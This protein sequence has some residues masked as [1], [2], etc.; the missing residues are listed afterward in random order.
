[1]GDFANDVRYGFRLMRRSPAFAAIAVATLA[2]GIGANT[3]IFSVVNTVLLRPLSYPQPD[4]IV[5]LERSYP[6]G[7]YGSAVS[8][9]KFNFWKR[10]TAFS[11]VAAYD[12]NSAEFNLGSSDHPEQVKTVHVSAG[13][14]QVFGTTPV[15][16]RTFTAEEDTPGGPRVAVI[17]QS[18]WNRR[19][20][21]SPTVIGQTA[22]L[23]GD[24]Y[25]IV[26]IL[27]GSFRP[28]PPADVWIPL[29][30][31]PNSTNQGHYLRVAARLKP[32]V[33]VARAQAE[34]VAMGQAFRQAYPGDMDK[35][36]SV[37]V[38]PLREAETRNVRL[39]LMILMGA[40]LFVLL[41]A[42]ANMANLLLSRA[43][44]RRKEIAIRSA[45]G[46]NAWRVVRQLLTESVLLAGIGGIA[47]SLLGLVGVR[48]LL[49]ASP[50][51]IPRIQDLSQASLWSV[52]DW[53]V[54]LFVGGISVLTGVIFG[55][56]PALHVLR[57]DLSLTLKESSSRGSSAG[58]QSRSRSVLMVVQL[59]LALVLLTGAG[60]LIRTYLHLQ[61]VQP[62]IN[63]RDVLT[64][65]TS[66]AGSKYKTTASVAQ[67]T[68]EV[69]QRVEALPGVRS[70]A[71][72][73]VLPMNNEVDLPF[74]IP[75]HPPAHGDRWN[76]DEQWRMVTPRYFETF[77][78][79]LLRGRLFDDRD[80]GRSSL[81]VVINQAMAQ[82]YWPHQDALGQQ[83]VIGKGLGPQFEEPA[84]QIIGIVGNVRETGLADKQW[85]GVMY[86]PVAQ[87]TD[88]LMAFGLNVIPMSWAVKT[89]GAP[90]TLIPAVQ[91]QIT[92]VDASIAATDFQTMDQVIAATIARQAMTTQLLSLFAAIA[93]LLA[94][95]G[96]YG[97]MSYG[98]E[99][100][101][102]EM[103][104]R[105]A[106]GAGRGNIMRLVLWQAAKLAI[107]GVV[108]GLLAALALSRVL[109]AILFGVKA[110]DPVAFTSVA[111]LLS[112]VVLLASYIPALRATRV[113]P[114]IALRYE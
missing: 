79:P 61:N 101:R 71:M 82:H 57:T 46:A 50:A 73:I 99:Q 33:S 111:I 95:V 78:I 83:I 72:M 56:F 113:D 112:G 66:L 59:A 31:D 36:E 48:A 22:L 81:V 37:G 51:D 29:Q 27:P 44:S 84:R 1:M 103:G 20:A 32:G 26:G 18:L 67:L 15:V 86:V 107:A 49:T 10:N 4:R 38:I 105:L 70:A 104:I 13:Y 28:D 47:G 55:I 25:T 68:R 60:L 92:A 23:N 91:R 98:V 24:L 41:M 12:Q 21:G 63:P 114:N 75:A 7:G 19:F 43:T 106:L 87:V 16:G 110:A 30:P 11:A 69:V 53:R 94:I 39:R 89:A 85:P 54:L 14:F 62:G 100:R 80:D 108:L 34:A 17:S 96:I 58:G 93:L 74:V 9:P 65:E 52:L 90:G 64:F 97:L 8:I 3:A 35:N 5:Q 42:C 76:G 109:S 2:L 45:A 88:G 40:V 6:Q 77:G 102:Q